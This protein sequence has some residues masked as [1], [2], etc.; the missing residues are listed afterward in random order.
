MYSAEENYETPDNLLEPTAQA[1]ANLLPVKSRPRYKH[2][3]LNGR[4]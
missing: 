4:I 2:K 1:S 3:N